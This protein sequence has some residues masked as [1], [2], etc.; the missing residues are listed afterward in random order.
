[1]TVISM[2]DFS[3]LITPLTLFSEQG[4][5]IYWAYLWSALI[6]AVLVY[7]YFKRTSVI[8]HVGV[9]RYL[10]PGDI[11]FHRSA[12]N[13]YLFFYSNAIFQAVLILP[14]FAGGTL[15]V[16]ETIIQW[17]TNLCS[18]C[19]GT[20]E[21]N[22]TFEGGLMTL[23]LVLIADFVIFFV[24]YLQHKIPWLWEFHKVH[25]SAEVL[26][27][28][29]VYRMHPV[30][31]IFTFSS[32]MLIFGF[33]LGLCN[34][35]ADGPLLFFNIN[36]TNIFFIMYY[37]LGYNLRH[38]HIWLSYGPFLSRILICPAQHQ[39]HHSSASKHFD[40]NMGFM[41]AFWDAMFNTL[42]VPKHK[43]TIIFGLGSEQNQQF[44]SYWSL[45]LMPFINIVKRLHVNMLLQPRRYFSA[46]LFFTV[47]ISA[48]VLNQKKSQL[49]DISSQ[50]FLEQLTWQEVD[51]KIQNGVDTVLLPTGGTEQNGPHLVLGKHNYIVNYTAGRV[52]EELGN[53]LVAPVITY[54][55]E[56][57]ISPAEGHMRY[58]GTLSVSNSVFRAVLESAVRSL[59]QH[60]FKIIAIIGDSG[61]NQDDQAYVAD[62]LN[63]LWHNETVKVI[64]VSDY[65]GN[66]RQWEYLS[67]HGYS[68]AQ[69]GSHAGIRDT[70]EL[71]AVYPQ[72]VREALRKPYMQTD[73]ELLGADGDPTKASAFLGQKLLDMKI[74]TAVQQIRQ[75]L[76]AQGQ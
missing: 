39:I 74:N 52:A 25:H 47:V 36:G 68:N 21:I 40:K 50:V 29:T 46:L 3:I 11:Y 37:L 5:R 57:A 31:N 16:S 8:K 64:H 44:S 24:H 73:S 4:Q 23:F 60:G 1:M 20:I 71:L 72:G 17:L 55:P 26:M 2:D 63:S 12:I 45:Y 75:V 13:D 34:F 33:F 61:G 43:E 67:N 38:S 22:T 51:N 48:V 19:Q 65:Y 28:L 9:F 18:A 27:P 42:Y 53:A 54:V 35:F 49:Q 10:F 76:S 15:V 56:G 7:L 66:N 59:K 30:D 70:S 14:L 69:I 41:F 6:L 62:K 32:N 58:A